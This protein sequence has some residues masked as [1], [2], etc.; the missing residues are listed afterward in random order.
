MV[1]TGAL[2]GGEVLEG[3]CELAAAENSE[4]VMNNSKSRAKI[5]LAQK[6]WNIFLFLDGRVTFMKR[7]A[8]NLFR[9]VRGKVLVER[10]RDFCF[11]ALDVAIKSGDH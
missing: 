1:I 8:A 3:V 6:R 5:W 2:S 7:C 9:R 11:G 10:G 4:M